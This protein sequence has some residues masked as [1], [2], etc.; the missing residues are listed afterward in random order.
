MKLTKA[1]IE[2]LAHEIRDLFVRDHV[3][4]I[5]EK[6]Q[7]VL[8]S[9]EYK[10][11]FKNYPICIEAEKYRIKGDSYD[12]VVDMFQERVRSFHFKDSIIETPN[13]PFIDKIERMI[14]LKTIASDSLEGVIS[15]VLADLSK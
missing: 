13:I 9:K 8:N 15:G 11:F 3:D 7:E 6:N 10:G 2:A 4:P 14:V 1:Q 12:R 5:R